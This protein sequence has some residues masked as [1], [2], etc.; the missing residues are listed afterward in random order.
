MTKRKGFVFAFLLLCQFVLGQNDTITINEVVIADSQLKRFSDSKS[1]ISLNDSIISRNGSA[2]T[3]LLNFNSPIY[4]KENGLGMVASP[5]FRG[6]TAQQTVVI[7]NGI[8]INSQLIGQTDFNTLT[9]RGFNSITVNPGGGSTIYG[10]SAIGGSVHLSNLLSFEKQFSNRISLSYGSFA[11]LGL[12]YQMNY[13]T[14]QISTQITLSRNSSD[15]DYPYLNTNQVNEN[16]A[17]YNNNFGVNVGYKIDNQNYLKFYSNYFESERHFSGTLVTTSKNKYDDLNTRNLLEYSNFYKN[18]ISKIRLA[19]LS[20]SYKYFEDKDAST[21]SFGK[22]ETAIVKY[23]FLYTFNSKIKLNLLLDY[24]KTKGF[25]SDINSN[26]RSIFSN[27]ALLKHQLSKKFNYEIGIRKEITTNYQSPILYSFGAK[28]EVLNWYQL[29]LNLSK[30]FRIPTFNDLYWNPGGNLDLNPESANQIDFTQVFSFKNISFSIAGFYNKISDMISWNPNESGLWQPSNITKVQTYG[31]ESNLNFDKK[32]NAF[33]HIKANLN[34]GYTISENEL[35][36]KQ[37]LYVPYHKLN[38]NLA[39]SYKNLTFF[40]SYLFNGAV[41][42]S[43]DNT[44]LLK[45]YTVVNSGLEYLFFKKYT[46]GFQVNN[47]F[48]ENYQ[49]VLQRPFPGRNYTININ[50]NLF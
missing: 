18:T 44:Y 36:K 45:E 22:A 30:N 20:E 50:L 32:I 13:A 7:W 37:L 5:S 49:A 47:L 25:G 11:T 21:F 26:S 23:D 4:F 29:K 17:F 33:H 24:T 12:E 43:L 16:G 31:L 35:T 19:F 48:N 6:T 15:N 1:K 2:L 8:N 10:T 40:T 46:L 38:G 3:S 39:Y 34:Y 28:Y 42:T 9:A 41:F 14:E 27:V